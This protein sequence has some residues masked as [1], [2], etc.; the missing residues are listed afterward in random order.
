VGG[1]ENVE[2]VRRFFMGFAE[3]HIPTEILAPDVTEA[4]DA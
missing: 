4:I 1:Q 3:G 2:I